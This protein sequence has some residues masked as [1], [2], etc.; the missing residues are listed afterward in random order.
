LPVSSRR[1]CCSS[2]AKTARRRGR[3]GRLLNAARLGDYPALAGRAAQTIPNAAVV[4]FP[5]LGHSPHVEA[6]ERF[7][8]A[9][10]EKLSK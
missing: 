1:R 7:H 9:L 10:L 8:Q 2:E 5:D 6:P 4:E 3:T